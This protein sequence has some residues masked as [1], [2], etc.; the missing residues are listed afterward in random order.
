MKWAVLLL[1]ISSYLSL[2]ING[3][4]IGIVSVATSMNNDCGMRFTGTIALKVSMLNNGKAKFYNF[5]QICGNVNCCLTPWL[6][7]RF[8]E[9]QVDYFEGISQLGECANFEFYEAENSTLP[10][11]PMCN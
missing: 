7:G 5:M 4:K 8:D 3:E 6:T 1:V 2:P 9:G 10:D 11:F